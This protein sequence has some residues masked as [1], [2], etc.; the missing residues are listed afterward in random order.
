MVRRS[1]IEEEIEMQ[2]TRC[3]NG[4]VFIQ[5]GVVQGQDYGP[6]VEGSYETCTQCGGSG[7]IP[8]QNETM[9]QTEID[10]ARLAVVPNL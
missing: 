5:T 7:E 10:L 1:S 8:A 3:R 2:C 6:E 4:R 9:S